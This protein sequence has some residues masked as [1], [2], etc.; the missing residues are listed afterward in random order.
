MYSP[1]TIYVQSMCSPCEAHVQSMC[2]PCTFHIQ[3]MYSPCAVHV[4]SMC[5]P[6]AVHVQSMYTVQ[7]LYSLCTAV[8]LC[9]TK[10]ELFYSKLTP[11]FLGKDPG[12]EAP[13][14]GTTASLFRF[15][16]TPGK[17]AEQ[18]RFT[19]YGVI[20]IRKRN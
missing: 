5:S 8:Q 9:S 19:R 20:P 11:I 1:C 12:L 7:S 6:C 14:K 18:T 3:S 15:E 2:S 4:Q 10:Q 17:P 16:A 13:I